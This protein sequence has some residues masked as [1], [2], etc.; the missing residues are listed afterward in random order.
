MSD[1]I[2]FV[3]PSKAPDSA[4]SHDPLFQQWVS[5]HEK[6]FRRDTKDN[7]D[8][9][10]A[11]NQDKTAIKAR[12]GHQMSPAQK[13]ADDRQDQH[14]DRQA[15]GD[16]LHPGA[17]QKNATADSK[18]VAL[19]K[20]LLK[21]YGSKLT[22]EQMIILKEDIAAKTKT[23]DNSKNDVAR[24]RQY[25][26]G[27]NQELGVLKHGTPKQ[28][29][30]ANQ[31]QIQMRQKD[32]ELEGTYIKDNNRSKEADKQVLRAFGGV[33]IVEGSTHPRDH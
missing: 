13:R 16:K 30:Q 12:T 7:G 6:S 14:G 17:D 24:E 9:Q 2:Q 27:D 10:D 31:H 20:A 5:L 3:N 25:I 21:K 15:I 4:I 29:E 23:G 26:N 8:C 22:P 1:K 33:N 28:I 32:M 18:I 11:L 19:D